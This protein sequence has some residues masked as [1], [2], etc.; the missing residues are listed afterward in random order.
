MGEL[1]S[2][3]S[4]QT[5]LNGK[6]P[7]KEHARSVASVVAAAA[8]LNCFENESSLSLNEIHYRTGI[9]KSRILRIAGTLEGAGFLLYDAEQKVYSIGLRVLHLGKLSNYRY[10]R[11]INTIEDFLV[12][13]ARE[14]SCSC[15]FSVCN[16]TNRLMLVRASVNSQNMREQDIVVDYGDVYPVYFGVTG[17]VLLAFSEMETRTRLL[18][19]Y[20][21]GMA[22]PRQRRDD[23]KSKLEVIADQGYA[24]GLDTRNSRRYC[25]SVPVSS[26]DRRSVGALSFSMPSGGGA[27]P[28]RMGILPTLRSAAESLSSIVSTISVDELLLRPAG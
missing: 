6:R 26:P 8:I 1:V 28:S 25:L 27:Q 19:E 4:S 15:Y 21:A 13:V 20:D 7:P 2:R 24:A 17:P 12:D 22:R 10:N 14:T 3:S 5:S 9:N 11:F 16:G 23:L 18:R